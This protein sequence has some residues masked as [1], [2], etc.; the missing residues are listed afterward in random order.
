M[1]RGEG[2]A[3]DGARRR[4]LDRRLERVVVAL[5]SPLVVGR[6]EC[7]VP[8]LRQLL[9]PPPPGPRGQLEV[10]LVWGVYLD[11]Q[12]SQG[13]RG[14]LDILGQGAHRDTSVLH[15]DSLEGSRDGASTDQLQIHLV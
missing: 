10:E 2:L 11:G 1:D 15:K 12:G 9:L 13:R 4:G 8:G 14:V 5:D 3:V 6:R 7:P